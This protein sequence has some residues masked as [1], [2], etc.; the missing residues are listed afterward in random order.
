MS[1]NSANGD[2]R[3]RGGHEPLRVMSPKT[4]T[5]QRRPVGLGDCRSDLVAPGDVGVLEVD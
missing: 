3:R 5:I 4:L 2:V 1:P